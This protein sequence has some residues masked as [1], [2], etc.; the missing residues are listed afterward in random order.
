MYPR[1]IPVKDKLVTVQYTEG[2]MLVSDQNLLQ[3]CFFNCIFVSCCRG[4]YPE[5]CL[6]SCET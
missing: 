4:D 6:F 3:G 5:V 1:T 2:E